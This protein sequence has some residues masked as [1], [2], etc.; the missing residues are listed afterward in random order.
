MHRISMEIRAR[1]LSTY[2]ES[3]RHSV[4]PG[5]II[6]GPIDRADDVANDVHIGLRKRQVSGLGPGLA[7]RTRRALPSFS[8]ANKRRWFAELAGDDVHSETKLF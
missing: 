7:K 5:P 6:L 1:G 8:N 3:G 4:P 2:F